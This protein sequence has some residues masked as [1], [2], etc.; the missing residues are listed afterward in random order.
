D[1]LATLPKLGP[2]RARW[3]YPIKS[4]AD[5]GAILALGSDWHVSTVN[6]LE[7]IQ[8]AITRQPLGKKTQKA[9]NPEECITLLQ[10]LQ[11]YTFGSAYANFW[12]HQTGSLE[13]G[14][15]ADL[16]VLSDNL[17][18]IPVSK[19][20]KARV[21]MTFFEGKEVFRAL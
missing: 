19:I 16:V 17:F 3:L 12:E 4:L 5:S 15:S 11:A 1:M 8:V 6:P 18:E 7:A 14:K 21:L 9:L 13:V 2:K 20:S 10:A